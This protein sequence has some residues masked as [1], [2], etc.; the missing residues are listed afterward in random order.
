MRL[1]AEVKLKHPEAGELNAHTRDI[2]EGGAF[3][4]TENLLKPRV[5]DIIEVQVQGLP[6]EPAPIVPMRVVRIDRDGVGLEFLHNTDP[7]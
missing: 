1:R 2:S 4:F 3:V 6:G 5:G 7:S